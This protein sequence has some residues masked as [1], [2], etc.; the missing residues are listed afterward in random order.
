MD[1]QVKQRLLITLI[2]L[3]L[4]WLLCIGLISLIQ[5]S[6]IR[7]LALTECIKDNFQSFEL[8]FRKTND[9]IR[10]AFFNYIYPFIPIV[11]LLWILWA[12]KL[13]LK[14]D[15]DFPPS[16][17]LKITAGMC[18]F[19]GFLGIS[20]PFYIVIEKD[21][22][23][24]YDVLIYN[25]FTIPW[26]AINWISIP[27]FFQKCFYS[28]NRMLEFNNLFKII[29]FVAASP[30]LAMILLLIRSEFKF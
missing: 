8:C 18:Y 7:S 15:G 17:V 22:G 10:P 4:I 13:N 30:F 23:Q 26:L 21:V 3:A 27:L 2:C 6:E 28:E 20:I 1:A 19:I 25:L 24:L 29:C 14:I 9:E 12:F 11:I 5:V 16:M